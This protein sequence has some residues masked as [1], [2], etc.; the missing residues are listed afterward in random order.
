MAPTNDKI[1]TL[2]DLQ[3]RE[4]PD[5]TMN[6][7]EWFDRAQNKRSRSSNNNNSNSNS[8]SNSTSQNNNN[9]EYCQPV[10]TSS[11]PPPTI[12]PLL[13]ISGLTQHDVCD[14]TL[15]RIHMEFIPII[16]RRNYNIK[17][18]SEMCCCGDG[19][20]GSR[21]MGKN[22]WGYNSTT[23]SSSGGRTGG[24]RTGGGRQQSSRIH[25]RLRDPNDHTRLLPWEDV[26]G[27]M[28]H[29]MAHCI[30]QNHNKN[31]FK[32]MEEILDEHFNNQIYGYGPNG[33]SYLQPKNGNSIGRDTVN[34]NNNNNNSGGGNGNITSSSIPESGGN[35]LGRG[36]ST[37]SKNRSR[38]V[39]ELSGGYKLGGNNNNNNNNNRTTATATGSLNRDQLRERIV[40]AAEARKRQM[41][42]IRRMIERSKE[43]CVIDLCDSD[44]DND[45]DND[46]EDRYK[47]K[48][49]REEKYENKGKKKNETGNY[50]NDNDKIII[51]DDD[52]DN[53][54]K[55]PS[56]DSNTKENRNSS[57]SSSS[58]SSNGKQEINSI[59]KD[60]PKQ[61][62]KDKKKRSIV[63]IDDNNNDNDKNKSEKEDD[64]NRNNKI[65]SIA[66]KKSRRKVDDNDVID[67]TTATAMGY[68]DI[69]ISRT[70]TATTNA[71]NNQSSSNNNAWSC[72]RCTF[73]NDFQDKHCQMC[74]ES[75]NYFDPYKSY[76]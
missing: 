66:S 58:S 69:N 74:N 41:A 72:G 23:T 7:S 21:R 71:K 34:N 37:S 54:E 50:D 68:N 39:N 27:T 42:H 40:K 6:P 57:S 1:V 26:A 33:P 47:Y 61:Q 5:G 35:K 59:R 2:D 43:P 55:K 67:L 62:M 29:E 15:K 53:D 19:L 46:D 36:S 28:A 11:K 12:I 16:Q 4:T 14:A 70:T 56:N 49:D 48:D 73:K 75:K 25:L 32:L 52:D 45:N 60:N 17:S 64:D 22:V 76:R 9:N 44:N 13:S 38:L 10:N 51:V 31:F 18:I 20:K 24:G 8:N 30:H 65:K 63:T 3:Y